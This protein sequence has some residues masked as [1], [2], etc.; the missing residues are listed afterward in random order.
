MRHVFAYLGE[1][2]APVFE[3]PRK[4][5]FEQ[6]GRD[7]VPAR[8][9]WDCNWFQHIE[10]SMDATHVSFVH[11]MGKIGTF[12][13]AV[14]QTIPELEYLE[15][16]AGIRQIA[17]RSVQSVRISD[18]T[19]PNHNHINQPGLSASD[20]WV[21]IGTWMIPIDDTST[22]RFTLWVVPNGS[23]AADRRAVEYFERIDDYTPQA[24]HEA[25]F[26]GEYPDDLLVCLTN[27][28]DYVAQVGQGAVA[29]REHEYL[30]RSDAGIVFLRNLFWRELDA[31]RA[32]RP[33]KAWRSLSH[34]ADMPIQRPETADA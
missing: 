24:H 16:D 34:A 2:E 18:W 13:E 7:A 31:I 15:T 27:A 25:L 8:R 10:N 19:F 22:L 17:T 12:G 1:G 3:L 14:T 28:Q 9:V 4:P 20:P 33:A 11:R 6:P 5:A 30:G 32:G 29:D 23:A 26:R 21:D